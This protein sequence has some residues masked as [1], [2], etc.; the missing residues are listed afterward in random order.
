MKLQ[1]AAAVAAIIGAIIAAIALGMSL[2]PVEQQ[3]ISDP[4]IEARLPPE[5]EREPVREPISQ[6]V[7]TSQPANRATWSID[8]SGD[9]CRMRVSGAPAGTEEHSRAL[10]EA[11]AACARAVPPYIVTPYYSEGRCN[12]QTSGHLTESQRQQAQLDAEAECRR[13]LR[14]R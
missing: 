11:R 9:T 8:T 2:R 4:P 13:M 6:P 3:P 7:T 5:P 10:A 1:D 12:I 14:S